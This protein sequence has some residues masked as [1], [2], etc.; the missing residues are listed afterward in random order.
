MRARAIVLAGILAAGLAVPT[1]GASARTPRILFYEPSLTEQRPLN[2][3]DIAQLAGYEIRIADEDRWRAMTTEEFSAF[4]AIVVGDPN[5]GGDH[6][7][8]V[9]YMEPIRETRDSW[10]PAVTG[11]VILIAMD[12]M[13]H[14]RKD[15][16]V[17]LT[18]NA[19]DWAVSGDSTGMYFSLS[20]YYVDTRGGTRIKELTGLGEFEV[21]GQGRRP[22]PN[23]PND[24]RV[25]PSGVGH[26]A[27]EGLT[28]ELLSNW[29]C[30]AHEAF[31]SYPEGWVKLAG[32]VKSRKAIVIAR[33][34]AI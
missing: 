32:E 29:N 14:Q 3:A 18:E 6:Y 4:D 24:I 9:D 34:D 31:D 7:G 15:G 11:Q 22:F 26:P 30:S 2:E 16:A 21:R 23:C 8:G 27:M 17:I 1:T 5:C 28:A 33:D 20:C 12:P 19:L 13:F 10:S 25:S